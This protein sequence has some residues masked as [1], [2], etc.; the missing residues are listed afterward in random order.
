MLG[1]Q[2]EDKR[3]NPL[4]PLRK[5]IRRRNV[6][7]V[8]FA[9]N[10]YLEPSD[11]EYSS[12]EEEEG[13]DSFVGQEQNGVEEQREDQQTKIADTS[14]TVAPLNTRD[15]T[16]NGRHSDDVATEVEPINGTNSVHTVEQARD[17]DETFEGNG[18]YQR[19]Y[20]SLAVLNNTRR[21][22]CK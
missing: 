4:N 12:E 6:K 17:S 22:R 5:A 2:D 3:A 19:T 21:R 10:S 18:T 16:V 20:E 8:E 13:N 14:A 1:D 9:G 11:V 7:K 15:R